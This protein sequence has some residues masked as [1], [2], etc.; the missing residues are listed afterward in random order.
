MQGVLV[1]RLERQRIGRPAADRAQRVRA[2]RPADL[3]QQAGDEPTAEDHEHGDAVGSRGQEDRA[4]QRERDHDHDREGELDPGRG[5]VVR[6]PAA[7]QARGHRL[8][9]EEDG[10]VERTDP[11]GGEKARE[12]ERAAA[13]RADD[14]RLEQSTLGV[15]AHDAERQEDRQ[16]GAEEERREHRQAEDGRPGDDGRVEPELVRRNEP[17]RVPERAPDADPVQGQEGDREQ[18]HDQKDLAPHALPQRVARDDGDVAHHSTA[19]R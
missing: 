19:S 15:A 8:D 10:D 13:D 16:H 4:Q 6:P 2:D 18:Q 7:D 14:E 11:C 9:R 17:G 1:E 5:R 3:G 12:Q